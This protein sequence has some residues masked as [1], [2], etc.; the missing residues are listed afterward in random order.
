MP[1]MLYIE[2]TY[3]ALCIEHVAGSQKAMQNLWA[4]SHDKTMYGNWL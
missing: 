2:M 3:H 4:Q 1:L